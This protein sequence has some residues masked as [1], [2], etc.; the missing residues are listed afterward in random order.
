M[1]KILIVFGTRPEAIKLAPVIKGLGA[2]SGALEPVVCVTGQHRHMLEQVLK[3]FAIHVDYDLNIMTHDQTLFDITSRG[4]SG[5][6][7]VIGKVKPGLVLV[8]GDTTTTLAASIAAF[9]SKVPVG[10]VE[11]GLRTYDKY[12]PFPEEK[13]RQL[14]TVLADYHFAPTEWARENLLREN[15][16]KESVWV[17]GNTVID[18]LLA[19]TK[20]QQTAERSKALAAY[21]RD[22]WN[23]DLDGRGTKMILVTGHRRENFGEKFESI[24]LALKEI[25]ERR[26]DVKI[27][28]PVHLN[29]NVQKPVNAILRGAHNVYLTSPLEYEPFIFLMN[30][31]YLIL[32]D[33][34]GIQEE[35]PSLGKPVLVMRETTE[36]PEGIEAGCVKVVGT[37]KRRIVRETVELVE[38]QG[39][40]ERMAKAANPYGD[41]HASERIIDV[42]LRELHR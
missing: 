33:S 3:L 38:K 1:K 30:R 14:T 20:A 9:Y 10:H 37:D 39:M 16:H 34:G 31:C 22:N 6:E 21:F 27:V 15:V 40:Y 26:E 18:A 32:T 41:G 8:Q 13:N 19:V 35:A 28:Y 29:P 11:A 7:A 25:A 17:T 2:T 23:L 12:Q 5:L 4:L 36:R 24:C 42:L